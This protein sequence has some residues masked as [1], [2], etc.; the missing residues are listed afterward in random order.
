MTP[1]QMRVNVFNE[2][3]TIGYNRLRLAAGTDHFELGDADPFAARIPDDR[4]LCHHFVAFV[5]LWIESAEHREILQ[6]ERLGAER[7]RSRGFQFV[8][9]R[10]FR[11][12]DS[13]RIGGLGQ[14]PV[15]AIL[16]HAAN[17]SDDRVIGQRLRTVLP[18]N[19]N[20]TE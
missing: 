6:T 15:I 18:L 14:C 16:R 19:P 13:R 11:D 3:V 4:A 17:D 8:G 1:I 5:S 7:F 10:L 9:C 12:A 20:G 2:A